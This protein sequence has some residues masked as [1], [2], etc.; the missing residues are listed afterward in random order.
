MV[1]LISG[2]LL[3]KSRLTTTEEAVETIP[4]PTIALP[5]VSDNIQIDLIARSDNQAV[6]IKIKGLTS[7]IESIEYELTYITGAGLPRGV[8][9]KIKLTGEKEVTRDDVVLGTC[10]SGKCAYD[11]GVKEVNLSLKFN[12]P[13]G[14]KIFQKTYS[15]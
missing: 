3:I 8:L 4:T 6:T 11:T 10:S 5:T 2:F 14:N 1:L 12:T 9:G 7:D 15:L 13:Q